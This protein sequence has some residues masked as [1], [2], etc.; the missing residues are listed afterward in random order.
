MCKVCHMEVL[1]WD[2]Q[3]P[4]ALSGKPSL[5]KT[6]SCQPSISSDMAIYQRFQMI[7]FIWR[8]SNR[9]FSLLLGV[10][11]TFSETESKSFVLRKFLLFTCLKNL[12]NFK[13]CM[14]TFAC[15]HVQTCLCLHHIYDCTPLLDWTCVFCMT[16][17]V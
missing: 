6:T 13:I 12:Q 5:C 3:R 4:E 8:S 2:T 7:Y 10:L 16:M 14:Y 11:V 1:I 9:A 17:H 15:L